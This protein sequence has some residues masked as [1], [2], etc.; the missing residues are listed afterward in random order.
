MKA[1]TL[2]RLI[3]SQIQHEEPGFAVGAQIPSEAELCEKYQVARGT[4]R[5]ALQRLADDGYLRAGQGKQ[6]V[7]QRQQPL[8]MQRLL[9]PSSNYDAVRSSPSFG[10]YLQ[11][12]GQ[13]PDDFVI[14]YPTKVSC[15]ELAAKE[16]RFDVSPRV[17]EALEIDPEAEVTYSLRVRK[18]KDG[19][20]AMHWAVVPVSILAEIPH[21]S[22]VPGGLTAFYNEHKI[23]RTGV[24]TSYSPSRA[25]R[26]EAD[27][28]FVSTGAPLL[29]EK[30]V[31]YHVPP[32]RVKRVPYEFLLA[33]YSERLALTFDWE[34]PP[35]PAAGPRRRDA[36]RGAT[37]SRK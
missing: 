29:E 16:P 14:E 35:T 26:F 5:A 24:H 17:S 3:R 13:E 18:T 11:A 22:L 32:G 31:S 25:S 7:V 8:R 1:E 4:I 10:E 30:R 21:S 2:Y 19:P 37:R 9:I 27:H 12:L 6:R 15:R 33:L 36:A 28:L 23:F 34:D 20:I